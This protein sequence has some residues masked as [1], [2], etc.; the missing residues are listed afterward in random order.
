MTN[1][2]HKQVVSLHQM[3]ETFDPEPIL[4]LV[5]VDIHYES[6]W[7]LRPID[8]KESFLQ[9][10]VQKLITIKAAVDKG[11]IQIHS[12]VGQVGGQDEEY[13]LL[14]YHTIRGQKFESLIRVS[15]KNGL[16]NRMSIEPV[17]RKF[18]I[19]PLNQSINEINISR[20]N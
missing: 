1:S 20:N 9:Y 17:K 11:D 12:S 13:F 6:H 10:I 3:W 19:L 2:N 15:V 14:L 4:E 16:I 18:N 8:G 5:S 7:V